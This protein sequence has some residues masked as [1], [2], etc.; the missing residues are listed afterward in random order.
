MN[1]KA[2][3]DASPMSRTQVGVVA[4]CLALNFIDGYDVLVM[5]FAANN[6]SMDLG[7]SGGQLGLLLASALLGMTLGALFIA[8]IADRIGRR[9]AIILCTSV[10]VVGMLASAAAPNYEMLLLFRVITGLAVGTMQTSLN[11]LVSEYANDRRRATAVSIY[12][13]GQPIGGVI[14]GLIVAWLLATYADWRITFVF[15]AIITAIMLPIVLRWLPESID[16]LN[17]RRPANA[18]ERINKVLA[19]MGQPALEALPEA[20]S[21]KHAGT[22]LASLFRNGMAAKSLLLAFAMMMIMGSFYF[23]NS[24]TPKLLTAT[25]YSSNAGI[26]AGVLFSLG[27]IFGSLIFAWAGARFDTQRMVALFAA[28]AAGAFAIFGFF[29]DGLTT[30]LIAAVFLGI[31]ANGAIAGMFSLGPISYEANVRATAVGMIGGIGRAGGVVSPIV[32]GALI[33]AGWVP[34]DIYYLFIVP[35][36]LGALALVFVPRARRGAGTDTQ[37]PAELASTTAH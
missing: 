7:L 3:I 6:I 32:A 25:G 5:A 29:A 9:N 11:V 36:A 22:N 37:R 34:A 33:D 14:G 18:L 28:A 35:L 21:S 19:R 17:A 27:S 16:H 30:A 23:A 20:Q 8:P 26:T 13:T 1:I 4:I 24:W 10:I 2:R 15:G 12:S 31:A